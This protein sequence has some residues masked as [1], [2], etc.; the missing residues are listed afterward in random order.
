MSRMVVFLVKL[1]DHHM[2]MARLD[3]TLKKGKDGATL[4]C[5]LILWRQ[6]RA[7]SILVH[8][9]EFR[10]PGYSTQQLGGLSIGPITRNAQ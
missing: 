4:K 5:N 9:Y 7:L 10:N 1:A 2:A 8:F 6:E 3:C